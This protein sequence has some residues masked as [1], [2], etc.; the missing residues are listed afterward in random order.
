MAALQDEFSDGKQE[1]EDK[2][3]VEFGAEQSADHEYLS[4]LLAWSC[5]F[6]DLG[7]GPTGRTTTHITLWLESVPRGI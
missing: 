7:G 3:R 6:H 1:Q 5:G 4:L 2:N